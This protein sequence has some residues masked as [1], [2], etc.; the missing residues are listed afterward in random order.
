MFVGMDTITTTQA[1]ARL[2]IS[3]ALFNLRA[4]QH[5]VQPSTQL[6]GRTG[7]KLWNVEDID[8]L[9]DMIAEATQ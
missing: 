3:R 2:G 8:R 9:R 7:A 6:P 4:A 1:V 5:D